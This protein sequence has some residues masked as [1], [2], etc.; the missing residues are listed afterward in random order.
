MHEARATA[1]GIWSVV[2]PAG[3]YKSHPDN[4]LIDIKEIVR[5]LRRCGNS[6]ISLEV[7]GAPQ[8]RATPS[9]HGPLS[10]RRRPACPPARSF[11]PSRRAAACR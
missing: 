3:I 9:T 1:P 8:H 4:F 5:R 2:K 10:R 7:L 11:R 6:L